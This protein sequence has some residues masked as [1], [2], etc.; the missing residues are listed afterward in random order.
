MTEE[1]AQIVAG[2]DIDWSTFNADQAIAKMQDEINKAHG[3]PVEVNVE[4]NVETFDTH[5]N[6]LEEM[7]SLYN[8]F[9]ENIEGDKIKVPLDIS[10]IEGLPDAWKS[11]EGF[12]EFELKVTTSTD[13]N[14]VQ[15][16]FDG[17]ATEYGREL[18]KME[19]M[20]E[21]TMA[22][23]KAQLKLDG[24]EDT[25]VDKLVDSIAAEEKMNAFVETI[26]KGQ[27][28]EGRLSD[29]ARQSAEAIYQEAQQLGITDDMLADYL[30]KAY[31]AG[32]IKID[33]DMSW[34]DALAEKLGWDIELLK[35]LLN[36]SHQGSGY[37][38]DSNG[39]VHSIYG[40][41]GAQD[42]IAMQQ[43]EANNRKYRNNTWDPKKIST[44]AGGAGKDAADAY[45]EAYEKELQQLDD[46]KDQ[47][48]ISEREYLDR[49]KALI[50]KYFKGRAEYA[51]KYAQE[52]QKY[53][54]QMLTHYNS[55]ISGATTL[56]DHRIDQVSKQKETI[57]S[58]LEEEKEAAEEAYQAQI[59]A[60]QEEI[61]ALDDLIEAKQEE[62][63][64]L[65]DQIDAIN[66]AN[67]ARDRSINLQKAEYELQRQM[68]QRTK[69]VNIYARG[70]S[71]V[72]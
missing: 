71:N 63:D 12:K 26:E 7:Q 8:Q 52:L 19:G 30:V 15:K 28:A 38:T 32:N 61:D 23:V 22:M 24:L 10:D 50:D 72:A 4:F 64:G 20:T 54:D 40:G 31:A 56:L 43:E 68:H 55:V 9:R 70:Y 46:L 21:E 27:D 17:M 35:E 5:D 53:M 11:L 37:V 41:K 44:D 33:G 3:N 2:L 34:L 57:I 13:I 65:N 59:D 6:N 25:G 14:E 1:D 45:V 67:A 49:L 58:S 66:E 39:T 48:L 60:I 16:A 51:E 42:T 18:L 47:G 36:L 29:S 69:L 62:I